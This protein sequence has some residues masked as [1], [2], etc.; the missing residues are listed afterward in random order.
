MIYQHTKLCMPNSIHSFIV[1]S[2]Q[3]C[4]YRFYMAT[5]S[6]YMI[7]KNYFN[8]SCNFQRPIVMQNLGPYTMNIPCDRFG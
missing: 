6:V 5:V 7:Q 8:K 1:I 4:K 3:I 2:K